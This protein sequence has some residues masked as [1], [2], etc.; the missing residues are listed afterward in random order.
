MAYF[1]KILGIMKLLIIIPGYNEAKT[2]GGLVGRCREKG[3]DVLV[4]DDGSTDNSKALAQEA[5]AV[6]I[7]NESKSGKGKSLRIGFG[8]AIEKAYDA[9]ITLDGDGQHDV[10]DI[11][12][13]V[14]KANKRGICVVVGNR[15]NN[16][17]GMPIVRYLTN[18]LMSLLI[19]LFCLKF[20]PD[21]QCG[22]RYISADILK[23]I[24]LKSNDFEIE[25][26]ILMKARKN[27]FTISS[28]DIR[29]I[30]RDEE[31]K[32][33]PVRDTLRFIIYFVREMFTF[34]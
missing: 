28:S 17:K 3:Y 33:K 4:I 8:Y 6:V 27:G 2:I 16:H 10:D 19:S 22:Y 30:Y 34:R 25:T 1:Q 32:I 9:V 11:K 29:T 13:F 18:R 24:T 5:G 14:D 23:K 7:R 26:E 21:T 12:G 31:S 15:M 20:I